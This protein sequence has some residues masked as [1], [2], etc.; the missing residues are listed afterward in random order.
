VV[1]AKAL[2]LNPYMGTATIVV[3]ASAHRTP[4]AWWWQGGEGRGGAE[5]R[6]GVVAVVADL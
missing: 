1:H 4:V 3:L 5:A 2:V 6:G